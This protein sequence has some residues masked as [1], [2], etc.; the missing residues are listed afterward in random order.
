MKQVSMVQP[1]DLPFVRMS[2]A[3]EGAQRERG[4]HHSCGVP[5]ERRGRERLDDTGNLRG[6]HPAAHRPHQE[7]LCQGVLG[8]ADQSI[9]GLRS[10][11]PNSVEQGAAP[12]THTCNQ[13]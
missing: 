5:H 6:A 4:S 12:L 8:I 7:H 2:T 13:G 10:Y 9:A 1:S 11:T 3:K